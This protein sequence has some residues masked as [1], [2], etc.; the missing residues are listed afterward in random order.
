MSS[1]SRTRLGTSG[2]LSASNHLSNIFRNDQF[3][4]WWGT[5]E[6]S[7]LDAFLQAAP[8]S[9]PFCSTLKQS[10]QSFP[11]CSSL[12]KRMHEN[13]LA[14]WACTQ[15]VHSVALV[16]L[17]STHL[18]WQCFDSHLLIMTPWWPQCLPAMLAEHPVKTSFALTH[19]RTHPKDQTPTTEGGGKI[20]PFWSLVPTT[21]L[22]ALM[23]VKRSLLKLPLRK[24]WPT[25]SLTR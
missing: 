18:T 10:K 8:K 21:P 4:V 17:W 12:N 24:A 2:I 16:L 6:F 20:A 25:K 11:V 13:A 15:E 5:K 1:S 22:S 3:F 7:L 14:V 23:V 19:A 9:S